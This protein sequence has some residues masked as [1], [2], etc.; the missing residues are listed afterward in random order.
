MSV[1]L[2]EGDKLATNEGLGALVMILDDPLRMRTR[3][4]GLYLGY[5]SHTHVVYDADRIDPS[6]H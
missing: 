2:V 6:R 3:W 4:L 1:R 5:N